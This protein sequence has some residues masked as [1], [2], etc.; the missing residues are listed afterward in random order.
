MPTSCWFASAMTSSNVGISYSPSCAVFA[1][2]MAGSRSFARSVLSS[3]SVKSNVNQLF[4]N[5]VPSIVSS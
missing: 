2:R 3:A 4:G 5:S 1:G